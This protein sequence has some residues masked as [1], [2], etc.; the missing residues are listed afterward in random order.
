MTEECRHQWVAGMVAV[1][2]EDLAEVSEIRPVTCAKCEVVWSDPAYD[3]MPASVLAQI[4][5]LYRQ[6]KAGDAAIVYVKLFTPGSSWTW[7]LTEY[8]PDDE[9]AF[10]LCVG[11]VAE[12][13][14]VSMAELR[15]VRYGPGQ[16][17]RVE[18][19][20]HFGRKTIGECREIERGLRS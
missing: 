6:D 1:D 3:L 7:Y 8:D 17:L 4:P 5:R 9:I 15:E 16:V 12:M 2:D 11:F 14:Y 10:G 18:R 13:G 19:D 20:L